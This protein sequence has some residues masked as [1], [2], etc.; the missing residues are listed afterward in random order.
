[1]SSPLIVSA[2]DGCKSG[3]LIA[4]AEYLPSLQ[5]PKLEVVTDF[6]GLCAST[7]AHAITVVDIPIGLPSGN[8]VRRCDV[9][10]KEILGRVGRNRVFFAPPLE[11]LHAA[12][13]RDF[14]ESH[15]QVRKKG[16]GLPVWGILGK[17][18][19]VHASMTP[20]LQKRILEYHPELV[21]FALAGKPLSPKDK[22]QGRSERFEVLSQFVPDAE[23]WVRE[24]RRSLR[25]VQLDDILDASIGLEL[26]RRIQT[27]PAGIKRLPT[28][29]PQMDCAGLRMEIWCW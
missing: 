15:R 22:E 25:G 28:G 27:N 4:S 6:A 26:A 20:T 29:P 13:P 16:A 3:W 23:S 14:Q 17:L 9:E 11:T 21:W 5:V 19:D 1:V 7:A 18:R 10:A 2:V 8:A 12:T 24:S